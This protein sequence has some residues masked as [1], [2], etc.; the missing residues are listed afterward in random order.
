MIWLWIV[1]VALAT[2]AEAFYDRL[3]FVWFIPAAVVAAAMSI[4]EL[5]AIL[6]ICTFVILGAL[7]I[8]LSR[9]FLVKF[10][11]RSQERRTNLQARIG[12]K[13]V[14]TERIDNIAGRGQVRV[15]SEIWS[16]RGVNIDDVF[17]VGEVLDV[18]AIEGVKLICKKKDSIEDNAAKLEKKAARKL[19][20]K[21]ASAVVLNVLKTVGKAIWVALKAIG[22]AL[23]VAFKG[24]IKGVKKLA[25]KIA[26]KFADM[27]AKKKQKK[28]KEETKDDDDEHAS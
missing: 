9:I 22:K 13:C 17:E 19:A 18:I 14:V 4:F 15:L 28:M 3:V 25:N 20:S 26:D 27:L 16:A 23:K 5:P 12:E 21:K 8:V 6:Q 24:I 2:I 11:P 10:V 7:G 1:V